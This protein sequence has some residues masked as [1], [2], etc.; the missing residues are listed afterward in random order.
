MG[1]VA[2][3]FVTLGGYA[4][5]TFPTAALVARAYGRD[6]TAEGS[7]NPGATNVYRLMGLGPGLLVFLGDVAKGALPAAAGLALWGHGGAYALGVAA[8]LGHVFPVTRRFKG[9]RGVAT[10]AGMLLVV[11]PF[12]TLGLAGLWLAIAYGLHR[13]SLASLTVT[14]LFPVLVAVTGEAGAE[15]AA[16][17]ALALLVVA[18]HAANLRR[19][20]RGEELQL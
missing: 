6:V 14:C 5:G 18:R 20:V 15:V 8:V 11:Y 19:L 13:A 16:T 3:T 4:V 17:S 7:G 9:G 2:T 12:V 10:A 1:P